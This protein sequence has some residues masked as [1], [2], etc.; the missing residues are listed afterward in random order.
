[1]L[2][3]SVTNPEPLLGAA[4][5]GCFTTALAAQLAGERLMP[6]GSHKKM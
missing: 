4:Q 3:Q 1:L 2:K 5:A 6:N